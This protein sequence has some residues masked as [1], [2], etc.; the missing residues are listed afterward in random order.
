MVGLSAGAM[1]M[2]KYIIITPCSEEYPD[3]QVEEGLNLDGVSIYPHNNTD[4]KEYPE[5]LVSGDETYVKND[6][7]KV[8]AEYGEFYLIQDHLRESG[9]TDVSLIK[10]ADGRLEYYVEN[11]GKIWIATESKITKLI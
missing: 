5:K 7:L 2:S 1:F 9:E 10:V 11:Q 6:L 3:F 8:A 4:E